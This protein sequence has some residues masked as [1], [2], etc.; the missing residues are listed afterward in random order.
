MNGNAEM[1][2]NVLED[3]VE[4]YY[5]SASATLWSVEYRVQGLP[6]PDGYLAE[7]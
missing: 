2:V 6:R 1:N 4:H 5:G 3:Q 7:G